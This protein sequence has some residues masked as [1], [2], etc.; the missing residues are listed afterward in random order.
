MEAPHTAAESL[1]GQVKSYLWYHTFDLGHGVVTQG[2]FDHRPVKN[3][4]LLPADLSGQRCLDVGTMD[5]FWA[6]EMEKR[7]AAEVMAVDIEDPEALDWPA[8]LRQKVVKTLDIQKGERFGLVH[9][10]LGSKVTRVLRSIYDL[11]FD[12]GTFDLVFCG[13]VLVHLKDPITALERIRRVCRGSAIVYTPIVRLRLH[14]RATVAVFD[15]IDDFQWWL[16]T[17][18]TLKRMLLAAGFARVDVGKAFP[19]RLQSGGSS[20]GMRGVMRAHVNDAGS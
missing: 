7:G 2:F 13:D 20:K 4:T 16:P 17:E 12:L 1:A 10:I 11:D 3:R 5:G 15:G 6:F 18:V 9:S 19:L 8:S 14:R